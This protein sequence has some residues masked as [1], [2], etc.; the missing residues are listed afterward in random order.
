LALQAA[1]DERGAVIAARAAEDAAIE[2]EIAALIE[3]KRA[4]SQKSQDA[5]RVEVMKKYGRM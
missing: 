2:A 4:K 3:K 1:S 5:I